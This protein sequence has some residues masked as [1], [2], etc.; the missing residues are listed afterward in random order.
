MITQKLKEIIS[1]VADKGFLHLFSANVMIQIVS[2][3]SQLFVAGILAPEDIGRIKIIQTLLSIFSVIAG[4]GLSSSTLK[5]CSEKRPDLERKHILYSGFIF[6]II[7][8]LSVYVIILILN[9]FKIFSSDSS[10]NWLLPLGILP[11]ITNSLY[12]L[13]ISYFQA[14]KSIKLISKLT[15]S[16]KLIS[17]ALIIL[18]S[19]LWGIT[20]YYIALNVGLFLIILVSIVLL[21]KNNPAHE[22]V[23]KLQFPIHWQYAK[24]TLFSNILSETSAYLDILLLN[25]FVSDMGEIGQYSFALTMTIIFRL[26][27]QTVQQISIPF[28]SSSSNDSV[29][30]KEQ[31]SYYNRLLIWGIL[32]IYIL[33]ILIVPPFIRTVFDVKY[34]GSIQYFLILGLGWSIRMMVQLKAGAIFGLG[35]IKYNFYI[36]LIS[37]CFNLIL[38]SLALYYFKT[39]GLAYATIISGILMYV[40]YN[41]YFGRAM[42]KR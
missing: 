5:L 16:N 35:Y 22:F 14:I 41:Y 33:A 1:A 7:F 40:L 30:I 25:Y 10:I 32:L 21:L 37:C 2:F 12:N 29:K 4:M 15:L 27:P 38:Y 13:F 17:I 24:P 36:S 19:F 31:A 3:A 11:L 6:T 20:G 8:T 34:E 18:F 39:L 28:F 23:S 42:K 9:H 26:F